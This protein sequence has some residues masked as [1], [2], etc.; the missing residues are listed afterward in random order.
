[1]RE[2]RFKKIKEMH[3]FNEK[4]IC[5][6]T[7]KYYFNIILRS[8]IE[9]QR[10]ALIKVLVTCTYERLPVQIVMIIYSIR[11][12]KIWVRITLGSKI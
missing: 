12:Y 6:L 1:L 2:N 5:R 3:V 4:L 10:L 8:P 11:F 9:Q 7:I